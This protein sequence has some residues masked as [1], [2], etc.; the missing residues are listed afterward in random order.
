MS[1]LEQQRRPPVP[2]TI[3]GKITAGIAGTTG[4]G[5]AGLSGF[6]VFRLASTHSVPGGVWAAAAAMAAASLLTGLLGMVLTYRVKKLELQSALELQKARLDMHR[7]LLEKAA[8]EPGSASSY[9]ELIIA[10]AL[11]LSVEQNGAQLTDKA[12][13]HLYGQGR[14]GAEPA[15]E[16]P[17]GRGHRFSRDLACHRS[18]APGHLR[19]ASRPGGGGPS[20][21][22][23][24]GRCQYPLERRL[25]PPP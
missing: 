10:D 6:A 3:F 13:Q 20:R 9:R 23:G 14:P 19:K 21:Y 11:H 24:G 18:G 8:G 5:S 4:V 25:R 12:H 7:T 16:L 2:S 1:T 17:A 22:E 15:G